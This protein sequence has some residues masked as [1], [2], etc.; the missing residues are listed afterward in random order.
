VEYDQV[1]L[2]QSYIPPKAVYRVVVFDS[3]VEFAYVKP[4]HRIEFG[5]NKEPKLITKKLLL[6][7]LNRVVKSLAKVYPLLYA[8]VDVIEDKDGKLWVIEVNGSPVYSSFIK[9]YGKKPVADLFCRIIEYFG[10]Q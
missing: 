10:R 8:G 5:G 7:K 3:K 4:H 9:T 2:A 1:A 6:G